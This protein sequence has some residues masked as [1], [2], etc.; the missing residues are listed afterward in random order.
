MKLRAPSGEDSVIV[1][2]APKRHQV[3]CNPGS[4]PGWLPKM[5]APLDRVKALL[6]ALP[7]PD[8]EDLVRFL[9]DMLITPEEVETR[10]VA[11]LETRTKG[12]KAVRYTYRNEWIRCG[13]ETCRCMAG[14]RHG[15]YTYRYWKE[16]GKLRK[17]YV[18]K[19]AAAA[20]SPS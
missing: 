3:L 18:G 7:R 12:G 2:A 9:H 11:S 19:A 15:P 8:Q 17:Q 16:E 13:R 20:A 5:T 14:E 1:A 4:L 6:A 10:H